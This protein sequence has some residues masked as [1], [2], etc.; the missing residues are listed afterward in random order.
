MAGCLTPACNEEMTNKRDG[1]WEISVVISCLLLPPREQN[2][3][4]KCFQQAP[5]MLSLTCL[6]SP[7][8]TAHLLYSAYM[9]IYTHLHTKTLWTMQPRWEYIPNK[10]WCFCDKHLGEVHIRSTLQKGNVLFDYTLLPIWYSIIVLMMQCC[11]SP[12]AFSASLVE[13]VH[14]N[15]SIDE[16]SR[17]KSHT[18]C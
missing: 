8:H 9:Y 13:W 4:L 2:T 5:L 11:K 1:E 16:S 17:I 14:W 18:H 6:V 15:M 10:Q 12:A 7:S 3:P